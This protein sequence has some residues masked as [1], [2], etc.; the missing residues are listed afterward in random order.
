MNDHDDTNRVDAAS[1]CV[2]LLVCAVLAAASA[3]TTGEWSLAG[4]LAGL[5]LAVA[6]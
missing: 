5:A 1:A 4:V 2:L 6:W 3:T